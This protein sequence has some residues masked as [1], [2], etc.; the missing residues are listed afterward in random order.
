MKLLSISLYSLEQAVLCC[1]HK[2]FY[3]TTILLL[4]NIRL[5]IVSVLNRI[6]KLNNRKGV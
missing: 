3:L 5:L 1:N 6:Q 4:V 2:L